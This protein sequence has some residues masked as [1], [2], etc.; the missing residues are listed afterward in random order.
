MISENY[1]S[2][3]GENGSCTEVRAKTFFFLRHR[4]RFLLIASLLAP[5]HLATDGATPN[6]EVVQIRQSCNDPNLAL[7]PRCQFGQAARWQVFLDTREDKSLRLV[8]VSPIA[9][10]PKKWTGDAADLLALLHLFADEQG[11]DFHLGKTLHTLHN[12][13]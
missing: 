5:S 6:K 8:F 13:I 7:L 10:K 12:V 3:Q 1:D 2:D 9:Y 11:A 4:W